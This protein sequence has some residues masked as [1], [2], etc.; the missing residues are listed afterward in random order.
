MTYDGFVVFNARVLPI[1]NERIQCSDPGDSNAVSFEPAR[2][3]VKASIRDKIVAGH[4]LI[5]EYMPLPS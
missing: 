1:H 5:L 2:A 3:F 4:Y